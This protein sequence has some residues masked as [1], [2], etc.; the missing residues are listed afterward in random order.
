MFVN[1]RFYFHVYILQ[2]V[3]NYISK[4]KQNFIIFL[5]KMKKGIIITD[6]R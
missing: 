6:T 2:N 1:F 5:N 4:N 3:D